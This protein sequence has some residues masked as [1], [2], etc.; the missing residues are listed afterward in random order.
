MHERGAV[1]D[2][3]SLNRVA[4][5]CK[6]SPLSHPNA[7]PDHQ[8]P[9]GAPVQLSF[10]PDSHAAEYPQQSSLERN[11][12]GA[13]PTR[14]ELRLLGW[15]AYFQRQWDASP[16]SGVVP[17]R[18]TAVHPPL[19]HAVGA[20]G[21]VVAEVSGR[22]RH[23]ASSPEALP[24][25]GD[26]VLLRPPERG[27]HGVIV[28]VLERRTR[29]VR[30]AAGKR[31]E[32]QVI[33][34]NLDTVFIVTS[35]NQDFNPRRIER[36]L[37]TVWDSGAIP[38]IVLSKADLCTSPAAFLEQL[39]DSAA[40]VEVLV[41]SV[42][43]PEG[44]EALKARVRPG[45]TI[46]LV[47]SSGVGK[48]T[49]VNHLLGREVQV[50]QEAREDDD[51]GKHTTTHRELFVMP[52]GGLLI[53]TPGMRELQLWAGEESMQTVYDD[54]L[55]LAKDCRFRD[56]HHQGEPGCG[57]QKAIDAG[58][59]DA[60]RWKGYQKMQR[61]IAFTARQKDERLRREEQQKWKQIS[62]AQRDLYKVR[63]R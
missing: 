25:V 40:A 18:I 6:Y 20:S 45:E 31:L 32:A 23:E 14:M 54:I 30:R 61:E 10:S 44:M 1:L 15:S 53:D 2:I 28:Q 34:A 21:P 12:L 43:Q 19:Y 24:A 59:L 35:A 50:T 58:Q 42:Y 52:D 60:D 48:S 62:K 39:G 57:I 9:K 37:T 17:A 26:W 33:A 16:V 29:F 55:E 49:L 3:D 13:S 8:G 38:V 5:S 41:V 27:G 11:E 47:G 36:Y 4:E 63:G 22:L 46:A 51:R 56:C 7:Y